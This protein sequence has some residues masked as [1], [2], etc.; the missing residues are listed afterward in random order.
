MSGRW[1]LEVRRTNGEVWDRIDGT[2]ASLRAQAESMA[3]VHGQKSWRF[4]LYEGAERRATY[5]RGVWN[6]HGE[7]KA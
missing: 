3:T 1:R 5:K 2:E 4:D 6:E 7:G